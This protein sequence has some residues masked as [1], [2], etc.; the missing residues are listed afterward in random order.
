MLLF[1]FGS[2]L[3]IF[4][5]FVPPTGLNA[6]LVI[7][8]FPL[9]IFSSVKG[10]L[11]GPECGSLKSLFSI[12]IQL[13]QVL[14][15]KSLALNLVVTSIIAEGFLAGYIAGTIPLSAFQLI[16]SIFYCVALLSVW[17]ILGS[18]CSIRFPSAMLSQGPNQN[19]N[20]NPSGLI[21]M[22][23]APVVLVPFATIQTVCL[24][25]GHPLLSL[26]SCA[27]LSLIAFG[28]HQ[29]IYWPWFERRLVVRRDEIYS[30]L[31]YAAQ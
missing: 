2:Y 12:P 24:Q 1:F 3:P 27:A 29:L 14:K 5:V 20:F 26:L 15:A 4:V 8:T 10:N 11:L 21:M 7:C 31:L 17:D 9:M 16:I 13:S 22:L 25:A 23:G 19:D 18:Y 28:A 6:T 30:S